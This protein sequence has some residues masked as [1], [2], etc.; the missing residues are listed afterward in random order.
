VL[1][2]LLSKF[3]SFDRM[4]RFVIRTKRQEQSN[5]NNNC[6]AKL[7]SSPSKKALRG[8]SFAASPKRKRKE[9]EEKVVQAKED[10][11]EEEAGKSY[12]FV[13]LQPVPPT[14]EELEATNSQLRHFPLPMALKASEVYR[15]K[16]R[17]VQFEVKHY[18]EQSSSS[19]SSSCVRFD[20]ER[21]D[22]SRLLD[23]AGAPDKRMPEMLATD[24]MRLLFHVLSDVTSNCVV[25][26][27]DVRL[28][29]AEATRRVSEL[30][31]YEARA[32]AAAT[33]AKKSAAVGWKRKLM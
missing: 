32:A 14:A 17:F 26:L 16:K 2:L 23:A 13:P 22:R 7:A 30:R 24:K 15:A 25:L 9:E 18:F 8:K 27:G 10:G 20:R 5:N 21:P 31:E 4:D 19:A 1:L 3:P 29:D 28:S 6:D 12:T 33:T 11:M